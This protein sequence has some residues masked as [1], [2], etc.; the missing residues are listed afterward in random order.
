MDLLSGHVSGALSVASGA[1]VNASSGTNVLQATSGNTLANAG[2]IEVETGATLTLSGTMSNTG[3]LFAG[4]GILDFAG[5]VKGGTTLIANGTVDIQQASTENITFQLGGPVGWNSTSP[6]S[7][8]AKCPGSAATAPN[9][10]T[11][12]T[13]IRR[14][15]PSAIRPARR[16]AGC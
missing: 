8:R 9:S 5:V 14:E 3:T 13:S 4:G 6:A 7:T 1:T 10:S 15:Q 2:V 12:P 16:V 11:S